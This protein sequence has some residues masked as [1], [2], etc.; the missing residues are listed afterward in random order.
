MPHSTGL[1]PPVKIDA[2]PSTRKYTKQKQAETWHRRTVDALRL[3][4]GPDFRSCDCPSLR[5]TPEKHLTTLFGS[6]PVTGGRVS[7]E[8]SY[9]GTC[10]G[11]PCA[12]AYG[13]VTH[14]G[15][16]VPQASANTWF[17]NFRQGMHTLE[18]TSYNP[19]QATRARL[20]L[21]GLG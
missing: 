21:P 9:S 2:D 14:Y 16:S 17:C 15:A 10:H 20:H 4:A 8:R 12:F 19:R 5:P 1:S 13:A 6:H 3:A 7:R 11:R 18:D